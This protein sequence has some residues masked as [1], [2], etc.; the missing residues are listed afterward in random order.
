MIKFLFKLA[1]IGI[2]VIVVL[3]FLFNGKNKDGESMSERMAKGMVKTLAKGAYDKAKKGIS[4]YIKKHG[5]P[6]VYTHEVYGR[7]YKHYYQDHGKKTPW[8]LYPFGE[9]CRNSKGQIYQPTLNTSGCGPTIMAILLDAFGHQKITPVDVANRIVKMGLKK[10]GVG[11]TPEA[12]I[13]IMESYGYQFKSTSSYRVAEN[14][15]DNYYPVVVRVN[16]RQQRKLNSSTKSHWTHKTHYILWVNNKRSGRKKLGYIFNPYTGYYFKQRKNRGVVKKLGG[17]WA[18]TRNAIHNRKNAHLSGLKEGWR[19][20]SWIKTDAVRY[21]TFFRAKGQ[22]RKKKT[23]KAKK[24]TKK[25]IR[26]APAQRK[27]YRW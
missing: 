5:P 21:Y 19:P 22:A 26:R 12:L 2:I 23:A 4:S 3:S 24:T 25:F 13:K 17:F 16:G 27:N 18:R 7:T 20:R 10:C 14:W 15:V 1:F 11:T 9:K 8:S 6:D